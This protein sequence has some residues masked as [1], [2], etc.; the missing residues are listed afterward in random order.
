ML[1]RLCLDEGIWRDIDE[2]SFV[3]L[4]KWRW[5]GGFGEEANWIPPFPSSELNYFLQQRKDFEGEVR[6]R[7]FGEL[8]CVQSLLPFGNAAT[9]PRLTGHL[10]LDVRAFSEL[11]NGT[12][13]RSCQ[14]R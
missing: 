3:W 7:N 14:D 11:S 2:K 4:A 1:L 5:R 12:F 10:S 9:I 6:F 8:G 13:C